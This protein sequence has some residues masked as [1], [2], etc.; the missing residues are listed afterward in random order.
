MH[1][2]LYLGK[3]AKRATKGHLIFLKQYLCEMNQQN[4]RTMK[5]FWYLNGSF[6]GYIARVIVSYRLPERGASLLRL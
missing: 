1:E 5:V 6:F 4:F 3:V 2:L